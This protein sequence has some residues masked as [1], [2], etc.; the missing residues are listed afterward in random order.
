MNAQIGT[1]TLNAGTATFVI[2]NLAAAR[3]Y[4]SIQYRGDDYYAA[5]NSTVLSLLVNKLTASAVVTANPNP[6]TLGAPVVLTATLS[7]TGPAPTGTVKFLDGSTTLGQGVL[8]NGVATLNTSS[9]LL[10]TNPITISYSGD[11][12]YDGSRNLGA[13]NVTVSR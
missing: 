2:S 10:G 12:N 1:A 8:A 11:A 9:L 6:A 4:L 3:H 7:S 5:A 13:V